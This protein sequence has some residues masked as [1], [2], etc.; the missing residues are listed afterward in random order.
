MLVTKVLFHLL[1][2][3]GVEHKENFSFDL[4]Q[5]FVERNRP[6]LQRFC[7]EISENELVDDNTTHKKVPVSDEA[8]KWSLLTLYESMRLNRGEIMSAS[9]PVR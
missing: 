3:S 6:R 2:T 1:N 7:L 5:N 4:I 9:D 8:H